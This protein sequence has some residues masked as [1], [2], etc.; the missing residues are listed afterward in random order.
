MIKKP[1]LVLGFAVSQERRGIIQAIRVSV[2]IAV[3]L[4]GFIARPDGDVSWLE[5]I[6]PI[7]GDDAGYAAFFNAIDVLVMGR[8][9]FEKVLTFDP[10][11]YGNKPVVVL[12]RSLTAVPKELADHVRIES[13]APDELIEKLAAEGFQHVYLDGGRVIQSFLAAGLVDD[14]C[15]TTIPILIG[16]G[17]PLFG[18][19]DDDIKLR[20]V[21]LRSWHNSMQQST[22][23]VLKE[24]L[25]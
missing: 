6:E 4:D 21:E 9:T 11:P 22:Y 24:P 7:P 23:H 3:S 13:S 14:L 10:W 2:F 17:R 25:G 16:A 19:L 1:G 8:G 15:I 12:S 18:P 20:L 5:S